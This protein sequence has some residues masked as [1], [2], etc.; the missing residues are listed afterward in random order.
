MPD[1]IKSKRIDRLPILVSTENFT[2][3][4]IAPGLD[5]NL[6]HVVILKGITMNVMAWMKIIIK[7]VWMI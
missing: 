1:N 7:M 5:N 4:V 3:I 2:T 6:G